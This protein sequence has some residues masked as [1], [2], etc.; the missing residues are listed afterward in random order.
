MLTVVPALADGTLHSFVGAAFAPNQVV[1]RATAHG[2][3]PATRQLASGEVGAPSVG[4]A[5]TWATASVVVDRHPTPVQ[6]VT[7]APL[8]V[9]QVSAPAK[10]SSASPAHATAALGK[11]AK[12]K[13]NVARSASPAKV[14]PALAGTNHFWFPALGI[15]NAVHMFNCAGSYVIPS[16]IWHFGCN[17]A[18]NIYLM[19]HAWSDF[20]ALRAAYHA[21]SLKTGMAAFYAGPDGKV[22]RYKVAWIRHVTVGTFNAGYWEWAINDVPAVTLQTCDGA[23]SEYRIIV[24]LVPG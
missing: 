15:S 23:K 4:T 13:T 12:V 2:D 24:R 9:D 8:A 18:R 14:A 17:S 1:T 7:S 16:G 3:S 19:S 21:G 10:A 22:L 6:Y 5:H 20:R 11:T